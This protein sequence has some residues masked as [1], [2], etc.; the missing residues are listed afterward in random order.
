MSVEKSPDSMNKRHYAF[1]MLPLTLSV[2]GW[3]NVAGLGWQVIQLMLAL[4]L[5]MFSGNAMANNREHQQ[6]ALVGTWTHIPDAPAVQKPAF[7]SEG[8]YRLRVNVDGT[9]TLLN[10]IKMKSPS[11]IAKSRDGRFAYVTNEED[12]GTVTALAIDDAGSV[13]VLNTVS[14]AGQQPTHATLSPD[15]K[16]LFVAN[17]SVANG[18]AGV[19]VLPIRSDGTLGE[20]VQHY[21][22]IPGSGIVQ[23]RQEGGHAHSTTFSRDGQYLY[24]ADLGGDKLHAYRY[25]PDNAQPLQADASRDVGFA[26]GAGPR[27]MVFS[28]E[29][30]Y[31]YVITEMAG[32]IEAFAVNDNRLTL[33]GKV[34]LNGGLDSAE[35]KSGGAII[36]SPSGRYLIATHRGT[37]NHLLVFKI[38]RDGLPSVPTRYEA[39]G[40][41]PRALAFDADGN[42]LYV[43]NVFTNSVTLFDFDDET[44]ELQARG[45]AATI[46]TPTDIKFFN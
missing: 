7:P 45:E 17:Y 42:R 39:G 20:R 43:T 31:A 9:L 24:A 21:P 19:T 18:G 33:R 4:T 37:D 28:P 27:H 2:S 29:G 44:G 25:R 12:A 30:E 13:R 22:F 1:G 16:F 6:I 23:G 35:A 34:K 14:S 46:S 32:E 15:G 38:G 36:L 41:E 5:F 3:V 26:P 8:L 40:I 11:W 10:V